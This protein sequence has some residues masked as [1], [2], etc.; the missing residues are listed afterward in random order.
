MAVLIGIVV[1][2]AIMSAIAVAVPREIEMTRDRAASEAVAAAGTEAD[3][4]L[5]SSLAEP[6]GFSDATAEQ[7]IAFADEVP[8]RLPDALST[9]FAQ[10]TT[11]ILGP[12]LEGTGPAGL[13]RVHIGVFDPSAAPELQV[14]RGELP[15]GEDDAVD[16]GAGLPLDVVIS[17]A[18]AEM[19]G[20]DVGDTA[21]VAGRLGS[22]KIALHVVGVVDA[23]DADARAWADLPGIWD[24]RPISS[25]GTLSGAT[26]TALSSA[27]AFDRV[28]DSFPDSALGIIRTSFDPSTFDMQRFNDV[29]EGIDE[30]E[31]SIGTIS[32]GASVTVNAASDYEEAL[33]S[34]PAAVVA[35][36]AQLSTL[37][38]GLVGVAVLITVLVGTALA[39]RR[40]TQIALLRSR[41][42]SLGLIGVH[43]AT[44][45]VIVALVGAVLGAWAAAAFGAR[46]DSP[47]LLVSA[48]VIVAAAPVVS[49][50]RWAGETTESSSRSRAIRLALIAVLVSVTVLAVIALRSGV[51]IAGNGVDPLALAAPVL[52]A[53][54]VALA[55]SPLSGAA[56]R[57]I[58]LLASRTRGPVPLLAAS[59]ARDGRSIL[60]LF[61]LIL[62][63]SVAITSVVLLQTVAA[64][65]EAASW[66]T[67][68]ADVR[69]EGATDAAALADEIDSAGATAATVAKIT[70][71]DVEGSGSP[72]N[73]TVFAVGNDYAQL[74]S[75]LPA[76]HA[77]HADA[78]AV[79]QLVESD[80]DAQGTVPVLLDARLTHAIA[81]D[82]ISLSIDGTPVPVT[83]IGS[84]VARPD[85]AAGSSIIVENSRLQDYLDG[86]TESATGGQSASI[87]P[88]STVLVTGVSSAVA[89]SI[90]D[91][92]EGNV[93]LRTEVLDQLRAGA[94]VSG[95]ATATSQSLLGTGILALL[96]LVVTTVLGARRRGRTLALLGA[97]GVPK[98]ASTALAA[99]ELVPL[100]A[101]GVVGG[102]L[103]A[104]VTI[105]A[106]GPAFGAATLAGGP[107]PFVMSPWLVVVIVAVAAAAVAIALAIDTPL[108][109]RVSTTEILR[110]G[111]ES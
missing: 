25:R 1:L 17:S 107:A 84:P 73:A 108:S 48:V 51:S 24:P 50:L 97:L 43:A 3:L 87:T 4:L 95:V 99:G 11:G 69:I 22:D 92:E 45:S 98:G 55:L 14:I 56:V 53:A 39:R 57:P 70:R 86:V 5:R 103:A 13:L 79:R 110:T 37:A 82:D 19:A 89:E 63:S 75:T 30:I 93:V 36:T 42:A 12:E 33:E 16:G 61:A 101:S 105:A 96:T 88:L 62:A 46:L 66:R 77:Q 81:G 72:I 9:V 104:A 111:E 40:R 10:V 41:G 49:T 38:A 65:Q 35:A 76:E 2:V 67:V 80:E 34:F 47:L 58:S 60:T 85:S 91:G 52:C 102:G 15:F 54:V 18:S 29:R 28:S 100:V 90:I 109:R 71:V 27:S 78:D 21:T 59:S 8:G 44:E 74:L 31:T 23:A 32:E 94:L 64:G 106:A 6:S 68:G 83:V 26:F 20:L 7:L